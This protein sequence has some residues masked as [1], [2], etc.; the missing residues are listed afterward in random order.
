MERYELSSSSSSS[1]PPPSTR[2]HKER[3]HTSRR[4]KK[5]IRDND[6]MA[7]KADDILDSLLDSDDDETELTYEPTARS[8]Y[9]NSQPETTKPTMQTAFG[10]SKEGFDNND[11]DND[12][13]NEDAD[14]EDDDDDDDSMNVIQNGSKVYN[15][16]G[17]LTQEEDSNL[18]DVHSSKFEVENED[19]LVSSNNQEEETSEEEA[20][21]EDEEEEVFDD[22]SVDTLGE[23]MSEIEIPSGRVQSKQTNV[24][25]HGI[26]PFEDSVNGDQGA[27]LERKN[28]NPF[29]DEA[30]DLK[31]TDE[32]EVR[33]TNTNPFDD[34]SSVERDEEEQST[35]GY[36]PF[37]ST[38][39]DG[40]P[41]AVGGKE[42][43]KENSTSKDPTISYVA[44]TSSDDG[45]E[46]RFVLVKTNSYYSDPALSPG[47]ESTDLSS[48][49]SSGMKKKTSESDD[50]SATASYVSVSLSEG[51]ASPNGSPS[52][53]S[54]ASPKVHL[55]PKVR[56]DH[57]NRRRTIRRPRENKADDLSNASSSIAPL[58]DFED[59]NEGDI[60]ESSKRLLRMA[61]QRLQYQ[62]YQ[63]EN[64]KLKRQIEDLKE[65]AAALTEQLRRAIETKCD[66]VL[67][68]TEM[69]RCH[70]QDLIAKDD[71]INDMRQFSKEL[72]EQK[73]MSELNFMNEISELFSRMNQMEKKHFEEL[74]QKDKQIIQL[75]EQIKQMKTASV[76]GGATA[77]KS[78]FLDAV[79]LREEPAAEVD[80]DEAPFDTVTSF[81]SRFMVAKDSMGEEPA[82]Q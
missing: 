31:S 15:D 45:V 80:E 73:S 47:R 3:K 19:S 14:D 12:N 72:I 28:T 79:S 17:T 16:R 48:P 58:S 37:E 68:Q 64:K 82:L 30:S 54:H 6:S 56:H 36:N 5:K 50:T 61:D 75:E 63:D 53:K 76:R 38:S 11:N 20:N 81:R 49:G 27:N 2:H 43:N 71:E 42:Q 51:V 7:E 39:N 23:N 78:R 24:A 13:D 33:R 26:N 60:I 66:L 8:T 67:A 62:M 44:T 10:Y 29:D 25:K 74:E 41:R 52:S 40:R 18:D 1:P 59:E 55:S 70:E 4:S 35:N 65:Q 21:E 34:E 46:A 22:D 69:E 77:F 9:S 57:N 32:R